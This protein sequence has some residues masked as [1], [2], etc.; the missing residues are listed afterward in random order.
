MATS[1]AIFIFARN[2]PALLAKREGR[3]KAKEKLIDYFI[4]H[5]YGQHHYTIEDIRMIF[6]ELDAISLLWPKNAKSKLIDLHAKWR[7]NTKVIG[8]N[9]G[10]G[11]QEEWFNFYHHK[12]YM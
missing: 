9:N 2:L 5:G 1:V 11:K 12:H 10:T 3:N 7:I 8:L 6:K 4:E